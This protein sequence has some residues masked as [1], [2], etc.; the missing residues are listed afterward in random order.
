MLDLSTLRNSCFDGSKECIFS[1]VEL[2]D[3][4]AAIAGK[5]PTNVFT[6]NDVLPAGFYSV[7]GAINF[8]YEGTGTDFLSSALH[9]GVQ[10]TYEATGTVN[11]ATSTANVDT[12]DINVANTSSHINDKIHIN[13]CIYIPGNVGQ[14]TVNFKPIDFYGKFTIDS[15]GI[16]NIPTYTLPRYELNNFALRRV[17]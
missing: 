9:L 8:F 11:E 12:M 6:Y 16:S 7:V 13:K 15:A 3:P 2:T 10:L 1:P 4:V 17:F 14:F 5:N